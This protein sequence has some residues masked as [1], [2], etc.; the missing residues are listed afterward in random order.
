MRKTERPFQGIL[1]NTS[2]LRVLEHLASL[3]KLDF[4]ITE[5]ARAAKLSRPAADKVAKKFAEWGVIEVLQKRGNMTF[6]KLDE[7]SALVTSFLAFDD[8]IAERMY[9]GIRAHAI[10]A[11]SD[12]QHGGSVDTAR[13]R[14]RSIP[15]HLPI[16]ARQTLPVTDATIRLAAARK[17]R[18]LR[19][20]GAPPSRVPRRVSPRPY[21]RR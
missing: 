2:E 1:G 18:P 3:P 14:A 20:G 4:N 21:A 10:E 8:S 16:I 13:S 19:R 11:R 5:L 7:R 9:P 15:E 17:P 12:A 6:Y